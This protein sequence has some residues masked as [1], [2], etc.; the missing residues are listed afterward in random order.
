MRQYG[1]NFFDTWRRHQIETFSALLAI[2]GGNS[3]VPGEFHTQRPVTR[4]FDVFLDPRLNKRLSKQPWG[5]WFESLSRPLWRHRNVWYMP[6]FGL[7]DSP[8]CVME[9]TKYIH[10]GTWPRVRW[11]YFP[12]VP[13]CAAY[14]F[15]TETALLKV[16]NDLLMA[17]DTYVGGVLILSDLSAAFNPLRAKFLRENI[18][19][20]LH[21]MSFLHTNKTQVAEI[22]PRVRRGSAYST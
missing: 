7:I 2:C 5:W 17:I 18:N 11:K 14:I 10:T 21:F 19:I 13:T 16:Q 22:P 6:F 15:C 8:D 9:T 3:P 1:S 20:Y 4:R 12:I